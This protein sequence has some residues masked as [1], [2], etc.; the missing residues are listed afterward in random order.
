MDELDYMDEIQWNWTK[1]IDL[2]LWM[3]LNTITT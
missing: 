2:T 3:K 1:R